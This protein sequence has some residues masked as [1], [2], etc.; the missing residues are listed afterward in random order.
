MRDSVSHRSVLP[1]PD[2]PMRSTLLFAEATPSGARAILRKWVYTATA[3]VRFA[4]SWPITY[5]SSRRTIELGVTV[6]ESK[7]RPQRADTPRRH[8]CSHVPGAAAQPLVPHACR[9]TDTS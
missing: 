8:Q 5:S 4:S 3:T 7:G 9:F 6:S 2:E 1:V